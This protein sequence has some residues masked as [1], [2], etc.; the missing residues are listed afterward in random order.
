MTTDKKIISIVSSCYNEEGNLQE[1]YDRVIRVMNSF[2][3]YSYEIIMAD[4][5]SS[6]RSRDILRQIAAKD[7]NFKVIFN[8]N[9]FG[10]VTSGYN[11]FMQATGDAC[12][13]MSSDLQDPPELI[14]DFIRKWEE[15]HQVV[16]A[17]R[18]KSKE[19]SL[20]FMMRCLY[21]R[22]L[23][24]ISD[25]KNLLLDFNGFGLYD[26]KFMNA[27][28]CYH[29]PIPYFRGLV[30]KIGFRQ[31]KIEYTQPERKY[32]YSKHN[33]LSLYDFA[34]S[35]FV[36]HSR[37]PL[38]LAIFSGSI[39]AGINLLIAAVY[40]VYKILYWDT[41]SLGL[42]PIVVGF[43]LFSAIQL[44]FIGIIGEY[45]GAIL[46]QVKNHPLVIEEEK[47]NF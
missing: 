27:L 39:I 46:T 33:F 31:T 45:I 3:E 38:R 47:L 10:P 30:S 8:S 32:G 26:R 25:T 12:V 42:A 43:F 16:A 6:D 17:I 20:K 35:G 37:I 22:F 13:L 28:K 5:R 44:I 9:N 24:K 18:A 29:E 4:N 15:G 1:F 40:F 11:A 41:F 19:N 36:S 34:I 21:Y 23:S 14:V 2:P 7:R